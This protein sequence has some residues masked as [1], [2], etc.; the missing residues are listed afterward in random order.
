VTDLRAFA[1]ALDWQEPDAAGLLRGFSDRFGPDDDATLVIHSGT[2]SEVEPAAA[3]LGDASPDML[4]VADGDATALEPHL[5]A[6]L[7][8]RPPQGEL[9][10]LPWAGPGDL[11]SLFDLRFPGGGPRHHRFTCNICGAPGVT[12]TR[13]WPRDTAS[14][15]NCGS[16]ARFRALAALVAE[17]LFGQP[18]T[19]PN[20]SRRPEL[21]GVGMSDHPALA[22]ALGMRMTYTNTFYHCEPR[23]DVCAPGD[24]AGRSDL[25]ICSEVFEHVPAPLEPA[26]AGLF[27]LLRPGGLLVFSVPYHPD[28]ET[29]EHFPELH[30][31][32]I[33]VRDGGHVLRNTTRDGRLME[34]TDLVFHGGPGETLELRMFALPDLLRRLEAAGF[35]DVRVR[36][37]PSFANGVWWPGWDGWPITARRPA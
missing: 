2:E 6:V 27:E 21:V 17:E 28:G 13:G 24:H 23:L 18:A 9:S 3:A 32:E 34:H 12:E 14:C 19:I 15:A 4:L 29:V 30:D 20:L 31:Y 10:G 36:R 8:G 16:A 33:V 37:E 11:R 5:A 7:S 26:F 22:A 25:V 1:A 35:A